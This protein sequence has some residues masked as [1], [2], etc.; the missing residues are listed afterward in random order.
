MLFYSGLF[1]LGMTKRPNT[2]FL[3]ATLAEWQPHY[4]EPLTEEDARSITTN[5]ASFFDTL[6]NWDS[7]ALKTGPGSDAKRKESD[8][9]QE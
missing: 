5:V 9:K 2:M 7:E 8:E 6:K 1:V 4:G 3:Q